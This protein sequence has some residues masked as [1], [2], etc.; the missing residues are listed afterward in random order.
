MRNSFKLF[1]TSILSG[2]V[3]TAG[4]LSTQPADAV[5]LLI[6]NYLPPKHPFQLHIQGPW[7]KRVAAETN[8]SVTIKYSTAAVGPAPKNW[9]TVTKGLADV[10]LL[11]N[12]FQRKRIQLPTVAGFPLSSPSALKTSKAL[13]AAHEK[14]FKKADEYKG[15][16]LVGSFV[17]TANVI[18]SRKRAVTAVTHLKGY[19]IRTAPDLATKVIKSLS[20]VP[21][22]SGPFKVFSLMSKGVVDGALMP[23]HALRAFK[24]MPHVKFTTDVPGGI[25][26]TSFSLLVNGKKWDGMSKTQQAQV[27]KASGMVVSDGAIGVDKIAAASL[28]A[29]K[30]AGGKVILPDAEFMKA[31]HKQAGIAQ[32]D[33]V[34]KANARGI[35]GKAALAFFKSQIK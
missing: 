17:L 27:M 5:E 12:I 24:L 28:E 33:W 3:L 35:D 30:K 7:G 29:L 20:G 9:Q 26:N 34:K 4:L 31:L 13:W 14:F 25:T 16:Q 10:V 6:N 23:S 8:G 21:V 1:T 11:A 32:A 2:A 15:T 22:P 19:K 18:H